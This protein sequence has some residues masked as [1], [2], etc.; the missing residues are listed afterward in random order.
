MTDLK[1]TCYTKESLK[2]PEMELPH[3]LASRCKVFF[4]SQD[5]RLCTTI[6]MSRLIYKGM[7]RSTLFSFVLKM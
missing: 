1:V 4:A 7:V 6:L 2:H 3:K 5:H